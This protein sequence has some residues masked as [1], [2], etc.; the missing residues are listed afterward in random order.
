MAVINGVDGDVTFAAGYVD[1]PYQWEVETTADELDTTPFNPA[2]GWATLTT[3]LKHGRGTYQ[4]YVD[5][6]SALPDAGDT[7]AATL[8]ATAGRTYTGTIHVTSYRV[9]VSVDGSQRIATCTFAFSGQV[10]GA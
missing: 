4:A 3:G 5:D 10:T 9:S 8:T 2:A 6:T 7:G 1:N